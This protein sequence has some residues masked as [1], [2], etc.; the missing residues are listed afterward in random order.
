MPASVEDLPDPTLASTAELTASHTWH[1]DSIEAVADGQ[2]PKSSG[3]H[4][5]ARH[6]FWPNKGTAEW[7]QY[8]FAKPTALKG[9]S[10]YWFDDSGRGGCRL[11]K[12]WKMLYKKDGEWHD[13]PGPFPVKRDV[14]CAVSF[15]PMVVEGLRIEIQLQ[16]GWSGGVLEWA[17]IEA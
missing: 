15:E 5:I 10:V 3:D 17:L 4:D 9:T 2:N 7:I 1:S 12:S 13:L 14:A 6:T 11:P 16:D 8:E